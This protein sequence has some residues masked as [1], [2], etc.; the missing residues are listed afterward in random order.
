MLKLGQM[1]GDS[2]EPGNSKLAHYVLERLPESYMINE[3]DLKWLDV[4]DGFLRGAA[5]NEAVV[6]ATKAALDTRA[7]SHIDPFE[8]LVDSGI[9]DTKCEPLA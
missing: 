7:G 5:T 8:L 1:Y 3:R 4:C 2:G 9:C 6:N